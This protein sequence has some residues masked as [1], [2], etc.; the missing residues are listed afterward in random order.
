M[1]HESGCWL[2][3]LSYLLTQ[4]RGMQWLILS[5]VLAAILYQVLVGQVP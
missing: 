2:P 4:H 3:E 5:Q 1:E